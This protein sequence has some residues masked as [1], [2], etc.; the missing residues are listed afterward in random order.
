MIGTRVVG[1]VVDDAG[2]SASVVEP[3][4]TEA[5]ARE[6]SREFRECSRQLLSATPATRAQAVERL[7][8]FGSAALEPLQRAI[9]DLEPEVQIAAVQ[10]LREIG[11]PGAVSLL[12]KA[13][14]SDQVAVRLAAA[15]GLG[16]LA[17]EQALEPLKRAYRRCYMGGSPRRER[18]IAPLI[19]LTL[20]AGFF[21]ALFRVVL[22]RSHELVNLFPS[23]FWLACVSSAY[24]SGLRSRSNARAIMNALLKVA[25][26]SSRAKLDDLLPELRILARSKWMSN[27][28]AREAA[29]VAKE[30]IEEIPAAL[31]DLPVPSAAASPS[32][33]ILPVPAG[34]P[35]SEVPQRNGINS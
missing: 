19:L 22:G 13:I 26:R 24:W 32:G 12:L 23:F 11:V 34:A 14:Q 7:S 1:K 2:L 15:E 27:P 21:S 10:A 8:D 4:L 20:L 31:R 25:A 33:E 5:Q 29:R 30:R 17:G 35:P 9:V 18:I 28:D 3:L 16:D 6:R